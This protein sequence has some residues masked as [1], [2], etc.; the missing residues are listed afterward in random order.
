MTKLRV[1]VG[2]VLVV[3]LG[4]FSGCNSE[5]KVQIEPVMLVGEYVYHAADKGEP[6]DPDILTLKA[7]GNYTLAHMPGGRVGPIEQG[8]WQLFND[9]QPG[10]AFGS[11]RYPVEFK[12]KHVRLMIDSDLGHWYEKTE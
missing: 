6:H 7:D 10:V 3:L 1:N 9:F 4:V 2:I 11:R 5:R 8:A 12:G